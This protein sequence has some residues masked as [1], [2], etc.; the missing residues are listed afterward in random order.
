[1]VPTRTWQGGIT[2]FNLQVMTKI[3]YER[4]LASP[5]DP[6]TIT[7]DRERNPKP[8]PLAW[9]DEIEI[10]FIK[11]GVGAYFVEGVVV[12]FKKNS[13]IVIQSREIHRRLAH[14]DSR[15]ARWAVFFNVSNMAWPASFTREIVRLKRH[16]HPL[17][18]EFEHMEQIICK[19]IQEMQGCKSCREMLNKTMLMEFLIRIKRSEA[20]DVSYG[21]HPIVNR[22]LD[23][24]EQHYAAPAFNIRALADELSISERHLLRLFM[25]DVGMSIKHYV[26]QRKVFQAQS[27]MRSD[28]AF[29]LEAVSEAAGFKHY[30]LFHRAF[31][32]FTGFPP[33]AQV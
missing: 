1:M 11:E 19:M 3:W 9:H 28:P 20:N 5:A 25:V 6:I 7:W 4:R 22:S 15:V 21:I 30:S 18:D 32:K 14:P 8:Y 33:C 2:R 12:P 23:Y 27:I 13:V 26:L 31:K 16:I 29:K 17:A 10:Q 24:I